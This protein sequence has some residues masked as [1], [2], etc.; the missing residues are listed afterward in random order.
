MKS[1]AIQLVGLAVS[2]GLAINFAVSGGSLVS[3]V[4]V[5]LLVILQIVGLAV[6]RSGDN[7]PEV[8]EVADTA[9][10][11]ELINVNSEVSHSMVCEADIIHQE[12]QRVDTIIK[13]AVAIL[14]ESFHNLHGL[15]SRQ[16]ELI[17]DIVHRSEEG[18]SKGSKSDAAEGFSVHNFIDQTSTTLDGF[19]Q[20]TIEVSR[21]SLEIVHHI[22]DMVV[23]LDGI[24]DLISN[25]E[26]LASQTNL[27][28]L[29]A[30]IEAARAG[31]AGR[32]FAVVADEVRT[33]SINSTGLNNRIREE[34]SDAKVTIENLRTTVGGMASTDMTETIET[35]EKMNNMLEYLN[36]M[37]DFFN[38]RVAR[39]SAL[40]HDL[41]SAV[42]NAVR[43]L[44]FEDISSQALRSIDTNIGSLRELAGYLDNLVDAEGKLNSGVA[45]EALQRAREIRESTHTKNQQ[46]TV[47]QESLDE[48]D[49]ELF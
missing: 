23:K 26:G 5:G 13:E 38:E 21:H 15:T 37:N 24:F 36:Q 20:T 19:V 29:N 11:A 28:A 12:V 39:I 44:Q 49:I 34:I 35:K 2:V 25:V 22:D 10:D 14:S 41:E 7:E 32:G 17:S 45:D 33:L 4:L 30:S 9:A 16:S 1:R 42:D 6:S 3:W 46:R 27:L 31:E 48:G 47:S 40:G 18:G 8:E 43:S